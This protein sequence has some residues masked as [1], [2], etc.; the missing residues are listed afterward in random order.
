MLLLDEPTNHLDLAA[1]E[2]LEDWL[3]RFKGAFIVISHDRTFLD[4]ADQE[5]HSGSTAAPCG[6]RRSASAGSR[7]GPSGSMPR[8]RAPPKSSTPS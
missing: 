2:W 7:P 6:A 3:E 5:L 1:I 8:K 4:A